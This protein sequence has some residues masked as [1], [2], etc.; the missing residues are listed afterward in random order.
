MII[1]HFYGATDFEKTTK[2]YLL[3][4][5]SYL[6]L[7]LPKKMCEKCFT[8]FGIHLNVMLVFAGGKRKVNNNL[9]LLICRDLLCR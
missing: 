4:S 6:K 5:S 2:F 8:A 3:N 1:L 9:R 7:R